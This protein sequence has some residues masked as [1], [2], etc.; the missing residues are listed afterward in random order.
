MRRAII[1]VVTLA[2]LVAAG[3]TRVGVRPPA[4][5]RPPAGANAGVGEASDVVFSGTVTL[6]SQRLPVVLELRSRGSAAENAI[7]RI[8]D[9][10]MEA[11]GAGR[12]AGNRLRL[13]LTYGDGCPGTVAV[14]ATVTAGGAEGTL[15]ARDCTGSGAGPLVLVRQAT[16][17][18]HP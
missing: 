13:D 18:R 10:S 11:I 5:V 2:S 3:C 9:V 17:E 8:P 1:A 4:T 16:G 12:W 15:E 14:D 6:G 7:L